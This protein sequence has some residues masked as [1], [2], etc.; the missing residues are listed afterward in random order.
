LIFVSDASAE[1]GR[2]TVALR[3]RGYPTV[4]VPLGL[5]AARITVQE[6]ALILCDADAG[7]VLEVIEG[8]LAGRQTRVVFLADPE[9]V[10]VAQLDRLRSVSQAVFTRPVEVYSLL[11]K[12]EALIG[13]PPEG[14]IN[15]NLQP[16]SRTPV[17]VA[18][19]RK[20]YM[21]DASH[22]HTKPAG[23]GEQTAD[24]A[25]NPSS[26]PPEEWPSNDRWL[27]QGDNR[28]DGFEPDAQLSLLPEPPRQTQVLSSRS[29][30]S[31]E[32]ASLLQE[33]EA[34]L[35]NK[36]LR[37]VRKQRLSPEAEIDVV[38]PP[39]VL[40]S[41]DEPL[42]DDDDFEVDFGPGTKSGSEPGGTS[43]GTEGSRQRVNEA[44][45]DQQNRATN[46][47]GIA[48]SSRSES[49]ANSAAT[50]APLSPT[51]PPTTPPLARPTPIPGSIGYQTITAVGGPQDPEHPTAGGRPTTPPLGYSRPETTEDVP[52]STPSQ[53]LPTSRP[54]HLQRDRL[55][56]TATL[57]HH[58]PNPDSSTDSAAKAD[59]DST[60][61]RTLREAPAGFPRPL[62]DGIARSSVARVV[63]QRLT[64]AMVFENSEGIRR[65]VFRDGDFV[66]AASSVINES[67]I[68][69]LAERGDLNTDDAAQLKRRL[70]PFGRHAGAALIANGHLKQDELW[71]VLRSHAEWIISRLIQLETGQVDW[72]TDVPE[73]LSSEP[74]VFGGS[75]GAEVFLETLRRVA[76][77]EA[78]A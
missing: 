38:L 37:D 16:T 2:L 53:P 36:P 61:K 1:A 48:P 68:Q 26:L 29:P 27:A 46:P 25:A 6:P 5:L 78:R 17:L 3:S 14:V 58:E 59:T 66:T 30:M 69:F 42:D 49:F 43:P 40:A 51:D 55:P 10:V 47:G 64:G 8:V 65:I 67:L 62:G 60:G 74:A 4:D 39:E 77:P 71:S 73:R 28:L 76:T 21:V 54:P 15:G 45:E 20:P 7:G 12:V 18:A 41:L 13:S 24:H 44:S 33:A 56:S 34:R 9:G 35:E 32:L 11:R 72:E 23:A 19:A 63:R 70:P 22:A 75:T 50:N 31:P 52:P 57:S